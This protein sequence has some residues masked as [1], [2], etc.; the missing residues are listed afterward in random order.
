MPINLDQTGPAHLLST[1]DDGLILNGSPVISKSIHV[2]EIEPKTFL[3]DTNKKL[4]WLDT[5]VPGITAFP[6]GGQANYILRTDGQGSVSWVP[7]SSLDVT[8]FRYK[9]NDQDVNLD[10]GTGYIRFYRDAQIENVPMSDAIALVIS[11]NDKLGNNIAGFISSLGLYGNANRRGFIK[12]EKENDSTFF[13]IYDFSTITNH[14]GWFTITATCIRG[15]GEDDNFANNEPVFVTFTSSGPEALTQDLTPYVKLTDAQTL[16]NKTLVSPSISGL[17]LSDQSITF[18]GLLPDA[19]ETVLTV[20]NPTDDRTITIPDATTTMVG[21]DVTQT[22]TNKTLTAPSISDP[23]INLT[24]SNGTASKNI[25][26]SSALTTAFNTRIGTTSNNQYSW[27]TNLYYDGTQWLKDDITRGAWRI[28]KV[29]TTTDSGSELAYTYAPIGT[30]NVDTLLKLT[31]QGVVTLLGAVPTT[32]TT[33][34]TLVVDGGVGISEDVNIGG[35]VNITGILDAGSIQ[36]TPIG[37]ISTS[38]GSFT[39]LMSTQQFTVSANTASTS[40]S[41]GAAVI[42]GGLG[43]GGAAH[44][45]GPVY[46]NDLDN[47]ETQLTGYS[48]VVQNNL[49]KVRVGPNYTAGA[50]D[51]IDLITSPDNPTITT[52]SDNLS[53]E[54]T[55]SGG[56]ITLFANDASVIVSETT[57]ASSTTTGALKV[58]GGLGVAQN[59]YASDMYSGGSQVVTLAAV[60]TMTNKT[61]N[62]ATLFNNVLTGTLTA[63]STTGIAGQLLE[64]TGTG[65]RWVN[66]V[67]F[68]A[69]EYAKVSD[70]NIVTSGDVS[71]PANPD[72]TIGASFGSMNAN[73]IFTFSIAGT[74]L[75]NINYSLT[76]INGGS[77]YPNVDFWIKK[78]NTNTVKY[79]QILT[80]A[81]RRSS[82]SETISFD[83]NDTLIWFVNTTLRVNGG[84]A[85]GSRLTILRLA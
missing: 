9:V 14:N 55:Q 43:I 58:A 36:S 19:Y 81:I 29:A 40:Q 34:G 18:E 74:Y 32:S 44:I 17:Y 30:N 15:K 71:W 63:N 27:T 13:Q 41:T 84:T 23:N 56:N 26:L 67:S 73:G 2:S 69:M 79:C 77:T 60:Q 11:A 7:P 68:S 64:S 20:V 82:V 76:D 6:E 65:V 49:A 66:P 57:A 80:N 24:Y 48:L 16:T 52:V 42:T 46:L 54:N 21:T 62:G 28:N 75:V 72:S 85:T 22:L 4:L 50:V 33:D 47:N 39:T 8:K 1:D 10:P 31:G 35:N 51:Y 38:T 83:V 53:I 37:S 5:G 25:T 78:N 12:V 45:N 70:Q 61:L 59:V 3:G